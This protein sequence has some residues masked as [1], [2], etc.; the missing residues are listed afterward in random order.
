M[1]RKHVATGR[2]K[3][4]PR[5]EPS[6]QERIEAVNL[7]R[8]GYSIAAIAEYFDKDDDTVADRFR[9]E[10]RTSRRKLVMQGASQLTIAVGKG[11]EWAVKFLFNVLAAKELGL[12]KTKLEL[13]GANGGPINTQG[14]NLDPEKLRKLPPD[15]LA[16]LKR[17]VG[18]LFSGDVGDP[19][20][21]DASDGGSE[22]ARAIDVRKGKLAP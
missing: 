5:W 14:L 4:R 15:E 17:A 13:T 19:S 9:F 22:F 1:P 16:A 3:G 21:G 12:D 10:L 18:S 20:G 7:I 8:A 6:E 2:P 11:E